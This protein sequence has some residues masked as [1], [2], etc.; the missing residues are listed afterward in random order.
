MVGTGTYAKNLHKKCNYRYRTVLST[1]ANSIA[2]RIRNLHSI[3]QH[4]AVNIKH[5]RWLIQIPSHT[6]LQHAQESL[7]GGGSLLAA[8]HLLRV[9]FQVAER[10]RWPGGGHLVG[11][12]GVGSVSG[13][14]PQEQADQGGRLA[15]SH[16][17]QVGALRPVG[18]P[19]CPLAFG[20]TVV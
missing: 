4:L 9:R 1:C 8:R 11:D 10:A 17:H 18:R 5:C 15:R 3:D 6:V 14:D 16:A 13:Q 19:G 2:K 20:I 12:V 7:E